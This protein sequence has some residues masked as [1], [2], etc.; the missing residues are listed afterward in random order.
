M[1][2]SGAAAA[3]GPQ[4]G[5][6]EPR[7]DPFSN[8]VTRSYSG[9]GQ[10]ASI[11]DRRANGAEQTFDANGN[12]LTRVELDDLGNPVAE[13]DYVYDGQNRVTSSTL[14]DPA[15]TE[16]FTTEYG[17][18]GTERSPSSITA[19]DQVGETSPASTVIDVNDATGLVDSVTDPDGVVTEHTYNPDRT[20]ASTTVDPGG[21]DLTTTYGYD[22]AGNQTSVTSPEGLVTT[23]V[24][25][26]RGRL[27]SETEPGEVATT[28]EYDAVGN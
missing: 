25:D 2:L 28:Y 1:P 9:N 11:E 26:S 24:Y 10:I 5:A 6:P 7:R 20:L 17:Y 13:Y 23:S 16:S 4:T 22:G 8:T 18:D 27:R 21:L 12:V 15:T 19:P 3:T 14:T